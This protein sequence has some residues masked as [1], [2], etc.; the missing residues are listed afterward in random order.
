MSDASVPTTSASTITAP[1][2]CLRDAPIVRS[3]ANS[4]VRCAIVI[5]SVFAITNEP[6]KRETN[7]KARSA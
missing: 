3:V 1:S 5:E 4:R 6:T 7:A 2:T